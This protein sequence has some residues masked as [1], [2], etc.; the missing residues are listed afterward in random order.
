MDLLTHWEPEVI[1]KEGFFLQVLLFKVD[2]F[3]G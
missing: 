1:I 2:D 3:N